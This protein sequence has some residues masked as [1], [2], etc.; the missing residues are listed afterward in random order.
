MTGFTVGY[1]DIAPTT[2]TGRVV[3]IGIALVGLVFTGI[4]IAVA[5]RS[6]REIAEEYR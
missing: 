2:P 3:S 1:G 5:T 4:V 6:L